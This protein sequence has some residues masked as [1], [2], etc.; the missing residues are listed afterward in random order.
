MDN[1]E[2][3]KGAE[4][5]NFRLQKALMNAAMQITHLENLLKIAT[6]LDMPKSTESV[7]KELQELQTEL[8]KQ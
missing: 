2:I 1:Q 7:L 6:D 4:S 5:L 8:E 3:Q